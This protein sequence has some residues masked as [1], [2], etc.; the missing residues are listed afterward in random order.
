MGA[1]ALNVLKQTID[2]IDLCDERTVR[3]VK[4][5]TIIVVNSRHGNGLI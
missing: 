1:P 4:M 2:M 5:E 3:D